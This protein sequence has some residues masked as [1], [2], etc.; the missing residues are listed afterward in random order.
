[1]TIE[2]GLPCTST[3]LVLLRTSPASIRADII[4]A[5]LTFIW[6]E[7]W[8]EIFLKTLKL[9]E[10]LLNFLLGASCHWRL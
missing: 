4:T 2:K 1:M 7:Q 8:W 5:V 3:L 10:T 9:F 6:E